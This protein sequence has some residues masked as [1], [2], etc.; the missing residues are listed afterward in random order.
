LWFDL[1]KDANMESASYGRRTEHSDHEKELNQ[2]VEYG[3]L[4]HE[5]NK[6]LKTLKDKNDSLESVN[7]RIIKISSMNEEDY[8]PHREIIKSILNK[9]G[10]SIIDVE[11]A[12]EGI[13]G[14]LQKYDKLKLRIFV[15][16]TLCGQL[17]MKMEEVDMSRPLTEYGMDSV[18][19]MDFYRRLKKNFDFLDI[20]A[21]NQGATLKDIVFH[22]EERA[23]AQA[24]I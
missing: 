24:L 1:K 23:D 14:Y 20:A 6:V 7:R 9:L 2:S 5:I 8:E 15:K 3:S 16:E 4:T 17:N 19:L 13:S 11:D 12:V 22:I 10:D 18:V 21:I